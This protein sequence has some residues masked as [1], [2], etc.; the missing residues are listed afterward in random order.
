VHKGAN[1]PDVSSIDAFRRSVLA[2]K[3]ISYPDPS[4]GGATGI[5]FTQ[6]IERLDIAT[7]VKA[8]TK[9]PPPEHFAVELVATGEAEAAIAQLMEALPQQDVE[10]AGLLPS[11]LQSPRNFTF[12]VGVLA[13]A[14]EPDAA[15]ARIQYLKGA[16]GTGR[17]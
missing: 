4:R 8:K 13:T 7:E 3:S 10:I 11:E 1:K 6:I 2:V 5:L 14:K 12:S 16:L 9:F 15:R 17:Y